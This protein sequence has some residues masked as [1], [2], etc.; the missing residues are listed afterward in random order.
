MIL[1]R[2]YSLFHHHCFHGFRI[3]LKVCFALRAQIFE[4]WVVLVLAV[5][6][7]LAAELFLVVV[8]ELVPALAVLAAHLVLA[9]IESFLAFPVFPADVELPVLA[10]PDSVWTNDQVF[11]LEKYF[12]VVLFRDG[13]LLLYHHLFCYQ[14]ADCRLLI[15]YH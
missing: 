7:A 5:P 4:V 8:V 10:D 2:S 6:P 9:E 14:L 11:D 13:C 12:L 1:K 15:P 3:L